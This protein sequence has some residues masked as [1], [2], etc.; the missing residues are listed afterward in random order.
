MGGA[1]WR[2]TPAQPASPEVLSLLADPRRCATLLAGTRAGIARTTDGGAHWQ[3]VVVGGAH[4]LAVH[5]LAF[6]PQGFVYAG[7]TDGV[8]MSADGGVTW[9]SPGRRGEPRPALSLLVHPAGAPILLA[10][11]G[12]G[13]LYSGDGG[14]TWAPTGSGLH[15]AVY[16]LLDA[17]RHGTLLAGTDA[18]LYI[19]RDNGAF[20]QLVALP[21]GISVKALA[22]GAR[23]AVFAATS[24]GVYQSLDGGATWR[25]L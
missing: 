16:C 22:A 21:A 17:D 8:W 4:R 1:T 3:A 20:W 15:A 12:A 5:A 9:L 11:S 19:S 7:T 25:S 14:R 24:L 18:G 23:H 2:P 13:L 10:G 6:G